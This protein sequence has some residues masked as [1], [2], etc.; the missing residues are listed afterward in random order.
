MRVWSCKRFAT[1]E[2]ARSA[3]HT[4]CWV[5]K[6]VSKPQTSA[7]QPSRR[8]TRLGLAVAFG[9]VLLVVATARAGRTVQVRAGQDLQAALDAARPGDTLVLEPGATFTGN[10]VLP[11][12]DD[13]AYITVRTDSEAAGP[14]TRIGPEA[15]G[16]LA[17]IRS[18]NSAPALA[19]APGA[20]HWRLQDLEFLANA[21]GQGE[22][23]RLGAGSQSAADIPHDFLLQRLLIRGDAVQGQRRGIALNS[24]ATTIRDSYIASIGTPGQDSQAVCGWNGPGPFLIEN[25]Y[26]E[27]AAENIMFGGADPSVPGLVPS[28]ITIRGNHFRKPLEWREARPPRWTVKNLLELKNARRVL[29]E[30][31]LFENSW[32]D[33]QSGNAILFTVRNQEG[34]APWSVIEDVTFQYNIVRHA[35]GGVSILGRDNNFPSGQARGLEIRQNLFHDIDGPR[36]GG[37]GRFILMGGAPRDVVIDHNTVV[38]S[39]ATV[40]AY[41]LEEDPNAVIRQ[42]VFTNNLAMHGDV[43]IMGEAG[44]GMGRRSIDRYFPGG[45]IDHNVLA[46][47]RGSDYEGENFFPSVSEFMGNFVD[48]SQGDFRLRDGSRFRSLATDGGALGADM[49]NLSAALQKAVRAGARRDDRGRP[50]L[51]LLQF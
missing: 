14:G 9:A 34:R 41:G 27:G 2:P 35:G 13:P 40:Y 36:W 38:Q 10:F 25:N 19:T 51:P 6:R 1:L 47:G 50:R 4:S 8:S 22:I 39:G 37:S 43:G 48:P 45:L 21:G 31:N 46:G 15:S 20:H 32:R 28:D 5:R 12:K 17:R 11:A 23:V 33:G 49:D 16:A 30:R 29:I 7:A 18:G 24:A 44:G 26:L 42:F 3:R